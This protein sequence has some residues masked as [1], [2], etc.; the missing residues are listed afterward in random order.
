MRNIFKQSPSRISDDLIGSRGL[1][2]ANDFF[3]A[4]FSIATIALVA[5]MAGVGL[6]VTRKTPIQTL[7]NP[8]AFSS[9]G[10]RADHRITINQSSFT[11]AL[12][13]TGLKTARSV[14]ITSNQVNTTL[15]G[16]GL[17]VIRKLPVFVQQISTIFNNTVLISNRRES[18]AT[19]SAH[20]VLLSVSVIVRRGIT[21]GL[22]QLP[23]FS[24]LGLRL[25]HKL[26]IDTVSSGCVFSQI[27]LRKDSPP[28]A[29]FLYGS[30][31][32][33][34][35]I[36]GRIIPP[37]SIEEISNIITTVDI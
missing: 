21:L 26:S 18:L 31:S 34:L 19:L 22:T 6:T 30:I 8:P 10:L 12:N 23:V 13:N 25:S 11:P 37:V 20:P 7:A 15:T 28:P 2:I 27:V 1:S 32:T 14:A 5:V 36:E 24:S 4:P 16:L 35:N 9:V 3:E 33:T 17:R 29:I